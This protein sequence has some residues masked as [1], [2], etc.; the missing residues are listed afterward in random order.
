M[1]APLCNSVFKDLQ[2]AYRAPLQTNQDAIR[3]GL[4]LDTLSH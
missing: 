2:G 1:A 4:P 3:C